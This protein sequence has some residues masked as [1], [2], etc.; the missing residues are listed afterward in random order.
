MYYQDMVNVLR[1]ETTVVTSH[2]LSNMR[3]NELVK[4]WLSV[5]AP[6]VDY[7]HCCEAAKIGLTSGNEMVSFPSLKCG[8]VCCDPVE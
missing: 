1:E 8:A 2:Y 4:T 6:H 3:I 7:Q 5:V